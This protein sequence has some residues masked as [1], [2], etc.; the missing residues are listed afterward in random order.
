MEHLFA[1]DLKTIL[2][3]KRANLYYLEYCRIL[4][5]NG[6]V[7]YLTEEENKSLYW[8]IPIANTTCIILGNGTSVTQAAMRELS[9]AGVM[10]GFC[11]GGGTPLYS[12]IEK[13]IDI[14][15]FSP[16][17]E[18]RPTEYVQKWV[19]IWLEDELRLQAAKKFQLLR[20]TFLIEQWKLRFESSDKIF[21][22][23]IDQLESKLNNH[24]NQ[25]L[26]A[27]NTNE[28]LLVEANLTKYLYSLACNA[29]K[30]G[31][32]TR[33]KN[34][35]GNDQANKFLDQGNYLAYGLAATACWV[36]GIP[37]SFSIL[38]GKT[39]R[40][41][42]VFDV[43]DLVKDA[44]ILPQAFVSA[45]NGDEAQDFR[46]QCIKLFL[47]TNSLDFMINSIKEIVEKINK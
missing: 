20:T 32:F 7:E 31:D 28:L 26:S 17:S 34:G 27:K 2:H 12:G 25:I 35:T 44:L 19:K 23:Q 21:N 24:T 4:V 22:V 42:L 47:K 10:V 36:L 1:S 33:E 30:Y 39:R 45:K 29:T 37:H 9:K 16:Q 5:N 11:G 18:Y 41:G 43:A 38:H 14:A 8:N 15:W 40:G 6:R 13:E 46:S 3:S